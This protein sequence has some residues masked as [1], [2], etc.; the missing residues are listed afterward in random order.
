MKCCEV[1]MQAQDKN[2]EHIVKGKRERVLCLCELDDS[3]CVPPTHPLRPPLVVGKTLSVCFVYS[4]YRIVN[5]SLVI[6]RNNSKRHS[7]AKVA[8]D[9]ENDRGKYK[10]LTM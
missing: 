5:K 1:Y 8:R 3:L 2:Q 6:L 7:R 10:R 4:A 9:V